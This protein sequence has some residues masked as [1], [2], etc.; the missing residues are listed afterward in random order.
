MGSH[1]VNGVL[2]HAGMEIS[3]YSTSIQNNEGTVVMIFTSV[4]VLKLAVRDKKAEDVFIPRHFVKFLRLG[5]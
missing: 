1:A 4:L 5:V 2:L 3:K